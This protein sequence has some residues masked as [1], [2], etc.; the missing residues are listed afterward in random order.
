M[1]CFRLGRCGDYGWFVVDLVGHSGVFHLVS[2]S[3]STFGNK[4]KRPESKEAETRI[5][6]EEPGM[7][8]MIKTEG[9]KANKQ[10]NSKIR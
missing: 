3:L 6:S 10:C 7:N 4:E 8:R 1:S 2:Y 5:E 9:K